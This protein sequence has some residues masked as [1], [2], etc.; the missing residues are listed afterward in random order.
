MKDLPICR[1]RCVCRVGCE[2]CEHPDRPFETDAVRARCT[3]LIEQGLC[4][5][6]SRG[7]G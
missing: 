7:E 3:L 5:R 6:Q 1:N 2:V 4:P